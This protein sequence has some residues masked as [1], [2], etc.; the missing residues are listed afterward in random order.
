MR[1]DPRFERL[2][3]E[4]GLERYWRE[5]GSKPDYRV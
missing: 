3:R 5:S 4:I 1:A 2:V